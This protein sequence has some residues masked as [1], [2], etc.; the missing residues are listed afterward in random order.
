MLIETQITSG[1]L[2]LRVLTQRIDAATTL[3][4][5]EKVRQALQPDG[6]PIVLDLATVGFID[7]S[8]LGAL[9][10]LHKT[11]NDARG[12]TFINLSPAVAQVFRLTRLDEVLHVLAIQDKHDER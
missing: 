5:K 11:L 10:G 8:G 2:H 12:I 9:V 6:P 1:R 7:S 3:D 4:F